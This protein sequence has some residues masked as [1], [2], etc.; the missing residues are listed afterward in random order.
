MKLSEIRER[1]EKATKDWDPEWNGNNPVDES[2]SKAY[3]DDLVFVVNARTDLED[4]VRELTEARELIASFLDITRPFD[5]DK[6]EAWLKR[7]Q[8]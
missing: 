3:P 8:P 5:S 4:A 1:V 7:V 2:W 6:A